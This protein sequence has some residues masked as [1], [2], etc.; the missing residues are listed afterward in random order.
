MQFVSYLVTPYVNDKN[1]WVDP[2]STNLTFT[3]N[4]VSQSLELAN[5]KLHNFKI[6]KAVT[7]GTVQ[8]EKNDCLVTRYFLSTTNDVFLNWH[9]DIGGFFDLRFLNNQH[10]FTATT[11]NMA[12][13]VTNTGQTVDLTQ[14]IT[15]FKTLFDV[16]NDYYIYFFCPFIKTEASDTKFK[17]KFELNATAV[18]ST[19]IQVKTKEQLQIEMRLTNSG[20]Q[21][22]ANSITQ[23]TEPFTM[24][25]K[26]DDI[27]KQ[28]KGDGAT[29]GMATRM[30]EAPANYYSVVQRN[31]ALKVGKTDAPNIEKVRTPVLIQG[32]RAA[33]QKRPR[34]DQV[35]VGEHEL[36]HP[37]GQ[38]RD[39]VL[40]QLECVDQQ[41]RRILQQNSQRAH[42]VRQYI[43]HDGSLL[44]DVLGDECEQLK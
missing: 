8:F 19:K 1:V 41:H 30:K 35:G 24:K 13:S 11:N 6:N 18:D 25:E 29:S 2:G 20:K 3:N 39:R 12:A 7:G 44:F 23:K 10:S 22:D 5:I 31:L 9:E 4:S 42:H 15:D 38:Q 43:D 34:A 16:K 21:V 40:L 17:V 37:I 33:P 14:S 28:V 36:L 26:F 27:L 32:D